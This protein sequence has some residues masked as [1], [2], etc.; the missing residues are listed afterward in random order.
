MLKHIH[1]INCDVN[2]GVH[3]DVHVKDIHYILYTVKDIHNT[4]CNLG[5]KNR[6]MKLL[7]NGHN[8]TETKDY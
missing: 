4:R 2:D 7:I 3:Y 1:Y 8:F 5:I 6:N